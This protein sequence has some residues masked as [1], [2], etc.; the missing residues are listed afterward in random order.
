MMDDGGKIQIENG[1]CLDQTET[2][3]VMAVRVM[4]LDRSEPRRV[5]S[6]V[7]A[8]VASSSSFVQTGH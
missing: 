4:P 3:F 7:H 5:V 1:T 2:S 8:L 6:T